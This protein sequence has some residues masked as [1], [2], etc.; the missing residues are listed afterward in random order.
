M[1]NGEKLV[2]RLLK[3]RT[4]SIHFPKILMDPDER[5]RFIQILEKDENTV[6]SILNNGRGDI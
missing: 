3:I 5:E 4:T 2:F 1:I 6:R